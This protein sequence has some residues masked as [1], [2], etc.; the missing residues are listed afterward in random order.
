MKSNQ[1]I[2][3]LLIAV[4]IMFAFIVWMN[5]EVRTKVDKWT[6]GGGEPA[7]SPSSDWP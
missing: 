6:S 7:Y 5:P 2:I 4:F 3:G 1:T